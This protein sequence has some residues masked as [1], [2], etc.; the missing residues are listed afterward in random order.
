MF[1]AVTANV[2]VV[3]RD[4][5]LTCAAILKLWKE[6]PEEKCK[7]PF[8]AEAIAEHCDSELL[9]KYIQAEAEHALRVEV[10]EIEVISISVVCTVFICSFFVYSYSFFAQP[11]HAT[12]TQKNASK[13]L[14]NDFQLLFGDHVRTAFSLI[15]LN[16]VMGEISVFNCL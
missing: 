8:C 7:E 2:P 3:A 14:C 5:V 4:G 13:E 16:Y 12:A 15:S 11:T 1:R 9:G 10:S 6:E